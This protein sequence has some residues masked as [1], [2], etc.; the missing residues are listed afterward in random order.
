[1]NT[2]RGNHVY[3]SVFAGLL[4]AVGLLWVM[5]PVSFV[6]FTARM[7]PFGPVSRA[8]DPVEVG[9]SCGVRLQL[10]IAGA[11]ISLLGAG[12]LWQEWFG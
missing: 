1:V 6:R 2:L 3:A 11:L 10:R 9:R 5:F 8:D 4:L 12:L 7:N